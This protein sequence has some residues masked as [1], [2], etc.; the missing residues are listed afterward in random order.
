[1]EHFR[2]S[3]YQFG[4]P[5]TIE[6]LIVIRACEDIYTAFCDLTDG[7]DIDAVIAL[8]TEEI[9][10]EQVGRKDIIRGRAAWRERLNEVRFCYPKRRVLHTPSNLRFHA[11]TDTRAECHAITA[12]Y[13][14][15]LNPEG[16][17]INRYSSEHV[18]YASEE[19]EFVPVDGI[20]KFSKR[21]IKFLAGAK[22]LPIGTLPAD[23]PWEPE[24]AKAK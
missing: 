14:L 5:R 11:V 10:V 24:E 4:K 20:W 9:Q 21:R 18:G 2:L 23:L 13:D 16:R 8:H 22:R 1:M 19:A 6:E 12:L 7:G 17:G 15:V 3:D